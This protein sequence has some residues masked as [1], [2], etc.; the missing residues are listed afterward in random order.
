MRT[1]IDIPDNVMKKA[2]IKAIE[3]GITLKEFFIKALSNELGQSNT[4]Q[5]SSPWEKLRSK[6]STCGI[7]P[8]ESPFDDY[9]GPDWHTDM[10]V[11]DP[12]S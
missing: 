10:Y 8:T 6:G 7:E 5:A 3:E 2:K 11:N 9:S 1:T 4:D 12:Q